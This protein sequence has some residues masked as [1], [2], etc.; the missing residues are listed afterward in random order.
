MACM[1]PRRPS[2][3]CI[4]GPTYSDGVMIIATTVGSSIV[5]I[6]LGVGRSCGL[7]TS[8]TRSSVSVSV[9]MASTSRL[10]R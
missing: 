4:T 10:T 8:M 1:S 3:S 2:H 7:E 6:L 5:R 9:G